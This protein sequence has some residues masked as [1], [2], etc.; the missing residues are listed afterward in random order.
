MVINMTSE[1]ERLAKT[2]N[3]GMWVGAGVWKDRELVIEYVFPYPR[4]FDRND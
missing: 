1:D 4:V 2:V 3:T